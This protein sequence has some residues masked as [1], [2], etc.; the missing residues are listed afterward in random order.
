M[1]LD[2][3]FVFFYY[4][5]LVYGNPWQTLYHIELHGDLLLWTVTTWIQNGQP[6]RKQNVLL[7]NNELH[8]SN[9]Y[10]LW[11]LGYQMNSLVTKCCIPRYA[12]FYMISV[13]TIHCNLSQHG[14]KMDSIIAKHD[15]PCQRYCQ[16]MWFLSWSIKLLNRGS[17][18]IISKI[19]QWL[20]LPE[21]TC[22]NCSRICSVC[23][24]HHHVLSSCMIGHLFY[25]GS[26]CSIFG[27][28]CNILS[29]IVCCLFKT[30][31]LYCLPSNL[32]IN[33]WYL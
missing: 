12:G 14:Y 1:S 10:K 23:C 21:C 29:T 2:C 15:N 27:I 3:S 13:R 24:N 31:S 6:G 33:P 8:D 11:Q 19:S 22:H 7:V 28:L 32:L 20:D 16:R 9:Y 25:W 17:L 30:K 5:Y 4:C 26:C 18:I